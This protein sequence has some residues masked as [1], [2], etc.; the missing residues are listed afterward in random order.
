MFKMIYNIARTELQMLFYS[1]VAWLILVV[2]GVQSGM[3]FA[4]KLTGLLSSQEMGY[5]I[6]GSTITIFASRWGGVF[7]T[8]QNYLYFYIPLLTMSLVSKELSSGSIRLLYSSPITNTQI[9]VGKFFSMMIYGLIMIGI[10]FLITLCSW[11]VVKD[12]DLPMVLVGLLGLYLLICSYAAIGIFMSSLTSYQIVA[13]IGT[14]AVLMVLS[15]IGGWWQDYDFI[16]DVTYWLSMPGR[17]GKFIAGLICS[18]DVL[19]FVIVVCLFLA[20]T[21]IR[22]NSVRQ[23]IR[24]VI[25]LGRNIGVIFLA[26]FLGYVS[27]LPT[28]KVYHDATA[29]KSNTLTPNSQDIVAKLDGGITITTYI[30]ALDPGAS[31]YAAPHFLKPDMARFEKYL[32]FKPDMKLKYVYY[33]D[34][35]SNPMLDKRFP[36]ATLR[37]KMVEVCKI[38]GL[39]SN[40][41][42][43]P[44]EIR[45]IIDLS[46]EN[47]T[48]VRQIV[49][50]NGEKAWLR[51]YNDMQRFPSEKEISA[52]FKRMVMD[53][54]KV[55]FVEG[56]G[57]RSYSGGK[58]R[59]YSAFA[60]DKGFRYALENQ[61]FDVAK[62]TMDQQVPEDINIIVISDM[63]EWFTPEQEANLQQYIDRGGNLFILGEPKRR[64]VMNNL[65]A[66]FGYEM[67]TG[68]LVKRDTNLQADVILSYPTKE[69]ADSIAYDFGFM[70]RRRM[71]ITTPS[72]AG[73]EQIAD[74]GYTVTNM[75]TTDTIG[76]WNEL[77]TT[78]FIDDTVCLN[79]AI[80]EVEKIYN[81]VVA[82]SRK[83]GNKEQ[84]IILTGDADC[85]SNGEF[86]RRVPT[87]RASNFSL[88]TGGFF[89]MSDNEVPIDVRRPAL[90]DN[91]VYVE[92][93]GSKVIKW[94][95]MIVLPLLLAGIGIFLWIRRKG[96]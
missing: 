20:L 41:F 16:R 66:K 62:V 36:N 32:R 72:T 13:A 68:V 25:T 96:R 54:P 94:S 52:A 2:F 7:T 81:T 8:M 11:A 89:W 33:Y 57:E 45:K 92:K 78:D 64:D 83:V 22:L 28:M 75:F 50:D 44:E 58:D 74:K 84:K 15:M 3:L 42:M 30:N 73:L 19:Y 21:I 82:L 48:F 76:V 35:T 59:D 77:E 71:V 26:C 90:P 9:I 60:N 27:A 51:I 47:N 53:L 18:E 86:G 85:I 61:G 56:H 39:D 40:K 70:R 31:W 1:P 79:P 49:R 55:G 23:K 10:L 87:A 65:F 24:F 14:F 37:E 4:D 46:G 63:R 69:A 17:S 91:K 43:G 34:T 6:E 93:T 29:T 88:I 5:N 95:F 38:Y 80:G 12:F 67:T